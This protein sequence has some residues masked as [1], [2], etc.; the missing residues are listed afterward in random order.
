MFFSKMI[1]ALFLVVA[2]VSSSLT[3]ETFAGTTAQKLLI[4]L[5]E[6]QDIVFLYT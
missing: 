3:N 2:Y 6:E 1:D 4:C 5:K